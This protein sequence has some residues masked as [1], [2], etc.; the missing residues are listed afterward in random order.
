MKAEYLFRAMKKNGV[1]PGYPSYHAMVL[2]FGKNGQLQQAEAIIQEMKDSGKKP[3][4]TTYSIS[5]QLFSTD[6]SKI[7]KLWKEI[8]NRP[9]REKLLSATHAPLLLH[10][11]RNNDLTHAVQVAEKMNNHRL[12]MNQN[13]LDSLCKALTKHGK[14]HQAE[15]IIKEAT[16]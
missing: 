8:E 6:H 15:K 4:E 16:T 13:L 5:I 9:D 7:T 1:L 10:F 3:N 2:A 11:V 12:K 14:Q